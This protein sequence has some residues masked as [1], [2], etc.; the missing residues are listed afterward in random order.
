MNELKNL[1]GVSISP[2]SVIATLDIGSSKI[3]CLIAE[4]SPAA[5][6]ADAD[7]RSGLRVLGF[8]VTASRGVKSGSVVDVREAECAIRIAVDSAERMASRRISS[9]HVNVSGGRPQSQFAKASVQTQTGTVSPRDTDNAVSAAI[10]TLDVGKR[11]VLHLMPIGFSLD[12][13]ASATAPLGLQGG[14]LGA[15]IALVSVEAAHLNNLS[16]AVERC[17]L[18][19]TGFAVAPYAAA[20]G[21][22]LADEI[23]LGAIVIEMGGDTTGYAL[24]KDG[25]FAS[26]GMI[27]IGGH[28]VT[29]D[30]AHGLS[31]TMAHA[32]RM[33]TMFG[34]VLPHGHDDREMLAVP[35]LGE[36]GVDT[37]QQVPKQVLTAIVRPRLEEIFELVRRRIVADARFA[38]AANRLV[39]TGGASQLQ[40][41]RE[42]ASEMFG[43]QVRLGI[44]QAVQGLPEAGRSAA[45]AVATGLMICAARP[46]RKYPMPQ[47][48]KFAIDHS[49]LTY[50]QRVG[51]WFVESL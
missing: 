46:D 23:S 16:L 15:E 20:R 11:H 42:L 31:T 33:K 29:Q 50:V 30:V 34:S 1:K 48:A 47:Q 19:V 39:L 4:Y 51:R 36:R 32:E 25:H 3:C 37:V 26:S 6:R 41:V 44:P 2:A 45:F 27:A 5:K 7:P 40:G 35:L 43:K 18:T 14:V 17:H 21:V 22:L 10:A 12:G 38:M 49:Q 28:H 13:V 9:V 24:Y 8:G